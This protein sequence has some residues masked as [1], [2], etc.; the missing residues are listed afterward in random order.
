VAA[1]LLFAGLANLFASPRLR[2]PMTVAAFVLALAIAWDGF[3]LDIRYVRDRKAHV[4]SR[5]TAV[6]WLAGA[7][8]NE[9]SILALEE[10][11]ILPAEWKRVP[12]KIRVVPWRNALDALSQAKADYLVTG[13]MELH[14]R[15][16]PERIAYLKSWEA[17]ISRLPTVSSFGE[18][19]T[20]ILRHIWLTNDQRI[21]VKK[22]RNGQGPLVPETGAGSLDAAGNRW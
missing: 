10:L 7:L 18:V 13:E 14:G 11:V 15:T 16:E 22:L 1:A 9:D 2:L 4:D 21:I 5:V 3:S 12:G 17:A 8:R 19:P 20:P 6:N